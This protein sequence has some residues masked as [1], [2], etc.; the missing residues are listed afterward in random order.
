MNPVSISLPPT[1]SKARDIKT[2]L[3]TEIG[4]EAKDPGDAAEPES[5]SEEDTEMSQSSPDHTSEPEVKM[6]SVL[7]TMWLAA[8]SGYIYVHS[9]VAQWDKCLHKVRLPDSVLSIA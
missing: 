9:A 8:Q 1:Q 7:S 6:S 4:E 2:E 5:L 3:K